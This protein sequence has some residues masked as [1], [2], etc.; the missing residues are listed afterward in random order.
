MVMPWG[1]SLERNRESPG[2]EQGHQLLTCL[3]CPAKCLLVPEPSWA[4]EE[5]NG[6][7]TT[8]VY[9]EFVKTW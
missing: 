7:V 3:C 9:P 4:W 5:A 2:G 6:L 1:H 8:S